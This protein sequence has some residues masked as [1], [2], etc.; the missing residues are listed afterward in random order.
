MKAVVLEEYGGVEVL[1][2]KEIP[3][4]KPAENEL[5]V[6]VQATA[7]NRADI[8]QRKGFYPGPP[9]EYEIPGLEFSGT[10]IAN[11]DDATLYK[12]GDTVMGIVAGGAYAEFLTV[13]ER[14]VMAVPKNISIQEAA[15]IPEAWLTAFDALVHRGNLEAGQTCLI[16][17]GASGVGTAAIQI[18]KIIGASVATTASTQKMNICKQLGAELAIDYTKKDY[19]KEVSRWTNSNGANVIVDLVGGEYLARNLKAIAVKGTIVQVGL[20]GVGKPEIDLSILLQKRL[21]LIGTV[22]RSRSQQEKI[23]LTEKFSNEMLSKFTDG[24]FEVCVDTIQSLSDIGEAQK[25]ME[26][27]LN[28]GK[29]IIEIP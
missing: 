21:K 15:G 20:M 3:T 12:E 17:A 26:Q 5:L 14:Q 24:E 19:V 13:H 25:R 27:N 28:I 9:A 29:I 10:V 8:L 7:L 1:Q 16:H 6:K 22:L 11:G 18:A 4:P 2:I 23:D